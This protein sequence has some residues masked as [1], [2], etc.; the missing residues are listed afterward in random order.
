MKGKKT[1]SGYV[2]LCAI[3]IMLG[4]AFSACSKDSKVDPPQPPKQVPVTIAECAPADIDVLRMIAKA[5]P[6]AHLFEG[7]NPEQW[8]GV[9][10]TWVKDDKG[11]YAVR[12][13]RLKEDIT[14]TDLVLKLD[15]SKD[16]KATLAHLQVID[17]A[18]AG[19][20][21]FIIIG[22]PMLKTVRVSG[23]GKAKMESIDIQGGKALK[24]VTVQAMP[25]MTE[26]MLGGDAIDKV[27]LADLPAFEEQSNLKFRIKDD[28]AKTEE[29]MIKEFVLKGDLSSLNGLYLRDLGMEKFVLETVLPEL[30][31]L[32]LNSNK[33]VGTL[34]LKGMA[35]LQTLFLGNNQISSL[36]VSECLALKEL[37]ASN[38]KAL[39]SVALSLPA[40]T[41]LD[42]NETGMTELDL[43]SFGALKK[44]SAYDSA[45]TSVKFGSQNVK[46]EQANLSGN[47]LSVLDF[48]K[49]V[50]KVYLLTLNNNLLKSLD[51]THMPKMERLLVNDNKLETLNV[52]ANE[53]DVE[54]F[55]D[56]ESKNNHLSAK[57]LKE[58]EERLTELRNW[59]VA[60]QS[61]IGRVDAEKKQI[62][63]AEEI[64]ELGLSAVVQKWDDAQWSDA[65][66]SDYKLEDGIYTIL[67]KGKYRVI[68]TSVLGW[69]FDSFGRAN[70]YII[71]ELTL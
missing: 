63:A 61:L 17:V 66:A 70:P 44:V 60:P 41:V 65:S 56:L 71:G 18:S 19:L 10:L 22:Q 29:T 36:K 6:Q 39:T 1:F 4:G 21:E 7:E 8:K 55:E 51:V 57:K 24:E 48:P 31:S 9:L 62:N 16:P 30:T 34:E 54:Y 37:D 14:I 23:A 15:G 67:G 33:L 45:L 27:A 25:Q 52:S 40:L 28:E 69:K 64:T 50:Q 32:T 13:F 53:S 2:L 11:K 47:K 12:E 68:C 35:K 43:T 58:I 49:E 5:N 3:A 38:N 59:E 20:K 46:L 26:I 42:L